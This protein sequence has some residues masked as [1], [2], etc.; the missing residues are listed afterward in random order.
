MKPAAELQTKR[1]IF[2]DPKNGQR[3]RMALYVACALSLLAEVV[4]RFTTHAYDHMHFSF[5]EWF[6][7]NAGW[8][9][10]TFAILVAA[11]RALGAIAQ[12]PEDFY[13]LED[14]DPKTHHEDDV[15]V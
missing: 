15:D 5:E 4:A 2:D 6:G 12:R 10:V 1:G 7:W 9:F 13:A 11:A 14:T 8:G 3:L